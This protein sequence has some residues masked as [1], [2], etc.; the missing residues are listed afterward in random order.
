MFPIPQNYLCSP[1]SFLDVFPCSP[2]INDIIPLLHRT[3][4]GGGAGNLGVIVVQ[5]F[6]PIFRNLPHSYTW[7][8]KKQ[9]HSYTRSPEMLTHSYTALWFLYSFIAGS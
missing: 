7:P 3:R 2:E 5:V 6:E 4:G 8:L 1:V 9:T